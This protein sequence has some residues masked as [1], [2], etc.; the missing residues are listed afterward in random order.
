MSDLSAK[1]KKK[2]TNENFT[3]SQ[4]FVFFKVA[5]QVQVCIQKF[6]QKICS[7]KFL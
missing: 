1:A 4:K 3:V 5:A 2:E 7:N 6:G